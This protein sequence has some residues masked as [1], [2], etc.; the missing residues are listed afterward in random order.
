MAPRA[1][2]KGSSVLNLI[3]ARSNILEV[4][5]SGYSSRGMSRSHIYIL[6][7]ADGSV[8]P[9]RAFNL[10]FQPWFELLEWPESYCKTRTSL[11]R[12]NDES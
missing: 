6:M 11:K 10:G 9:Q 12:T 7:V 5:I 8:T 3:L 4:L 2:A 1:E